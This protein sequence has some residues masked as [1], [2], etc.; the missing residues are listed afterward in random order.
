MAVSL[1]TC[2]VLLEDCVYTG[3]LART[4]RIFVSGIPHHITQRRSR[5][6][7]VFFNEVDYRFYRGLLSEHCR[8]EGVQGWAYCLIPNHIH[9]VAVPERHDSL[10]RAFGKTHERYAKRMNRREGWTGHLWQERFHSVPMDEPHTISAI[11][12]V[13]LNPVRAG[14]VERPEDWPFS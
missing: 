11:R 8:R 2:K 1:G 5:R 10:A 13:L 14:L 6:L 9:C 3:H 4:P 12:Y 7:Q